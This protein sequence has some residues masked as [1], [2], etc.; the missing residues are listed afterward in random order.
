MPNT[1]GLRAP[2]VLTGLPQGRQA[3]YQGSN[4]Q[5]YASRDANQLLVV[6]F[7]RIAVMRITMQSA[8]AWRPRVH[9]A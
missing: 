4:V 8:F 5:T 7:V 1:T 9:Y 3:D 2:K 6:W